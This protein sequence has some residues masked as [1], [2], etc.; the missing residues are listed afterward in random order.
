M[1]ADPELYE[2]ERSE[3]IHLAVNGLRSVARARQHLND[4]WAAVG[5]T[6]CEFADGNVA[7]VA[8]LHVATEEL[9]VIAG[10]P[11]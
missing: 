11:Y 4:L 1:I 5:T 7:R 9:E 10:E 3:L 2:E 6:L 8:R